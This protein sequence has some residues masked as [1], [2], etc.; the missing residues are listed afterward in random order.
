[1][2]WSPFVRWISVE[3]VLLDA[4]AV[5]KLARDAGLDVVVARED[6]AIVVSTRSGEPLLDVDITGPGSDG[7]FAEE[8]EE[9]AGRLEGAALALNAL[10]CRRI[11]KEAVVI[12]GVGA[13]H[14]EEPELADAI[15]AQVLGA[16]GLATEGVFF[17][18]GDGFSN[19]HGALIVADPEADPDED[20]ARVIGLLDDETWISAAL[21]GPA[22]LKALAGGALPDGVEV[23]RNPSTFARTLK[24]GPR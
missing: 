3:P 22:A 11:V 24:R 4:A 18:E 1:M 23:E 19:R 5:R 14:D 7:M 6:D 13:Y 17:S 8:I 12:V 9:F 10:F 20:A 16:L 21:T 15:M 2:S